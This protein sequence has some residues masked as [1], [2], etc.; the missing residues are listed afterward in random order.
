MWL[1]EDSG[2]HKQVSQNVVF[3]KAQMINVNTYFSELEEV[4]G[5]NELINRFEELKNL[6]GIL[7]PYLWILLMSYNRETTMEKGTVYVRF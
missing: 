5:G 4:P 7:K 1:D 2:L 6:K 3:P